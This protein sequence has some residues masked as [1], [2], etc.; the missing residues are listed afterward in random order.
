MIDEIKIRQF[1]DLTQNDPQN[2]LGFFSLGRAYIDGGSP[3]EAIAPLM[4]AISL[5]P[6]LSRAYVLLAQGQIAVG[7]SEGAQNTLLR[8]HKVAQEH[9]D[10]MPRNQMAAMLKEMGAALPE[11]APQ[12]LTPELSAQGNIQCRRCNRVGPKMAERPFG[13]ALGTQIHESVCGP[14]FQLWIRQG[15]KV[16]NELR[17][18]L[19]EPQSQDTYDQHMKEFLSLN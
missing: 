2:D 4:R 1:T 11:E 18:N 17:L 15:T 6:S 9:G 13:G 10:L 19:T 7:D 16:I 5:N 8:G 3:K 14:C 12:P